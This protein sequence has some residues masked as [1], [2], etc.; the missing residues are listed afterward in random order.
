MPAYDFIVMLYSPNCYN[1]CS[2]SALS[3]CNLLACYMRST[4]QTILYIISVALVVA[5]LH[6]VEKKLLPGICREQ[7]VEM[8]LYEGS[9]FPAVNESCSALLLPCLP[10]LLGTLCMH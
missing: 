3:A 9:F 2:A 7:V 6:Q 10:I 5:A 8:L 1:S 4:S